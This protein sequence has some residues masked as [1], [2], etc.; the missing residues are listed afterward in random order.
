MP[1]PQT[2]LPFEWLR[3]PWGP[4]LRCAALATVADHCFTTRRPVLPAGVGAPGDGW[5][6]LAFT[7]GVARTSL[8][9]LKQVHGCDV[10]VVRNGSRDHAASPDDGNWAAAD[11]SVSD[12][13]SVALCVKVADCV[14]LLIADHRT[15][16]VAAVH[17][18][19]RGAAAGIVGAAIE[20]LA[21]Q[22]SS[23]PEDLVAAIG[24]SIGP[25]CYR[26]GAELRDEFVTRGRASSDV[27]RWLTLQAT[28]PAVHGVPGVIPVSA[29]GEPPLWLDM[30]QVVADQLVMAGLD[31]GNVHVA[32]LCTSCH[33]D[34]FHS[35][36]VDGP[37]AGRMVGIIKAGR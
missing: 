8:V 13:P 15:G 27:S 9:R 29:N 12:D 34:T 3:H 1:E 4:A 36:R 16:A 22:F 21:A 31:P 17:A 2:S 37:H 26:V 5:Q 11:A 33:R 30:W 6:S 7:F 10:L 23:R 32:G 18:G 25:C 24:P 20:M 35:Y 14:P 19:W 28:R